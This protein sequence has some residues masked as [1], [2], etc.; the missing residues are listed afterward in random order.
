MLQSNGFSLEQVRGTVEQL[1]VQ[2]SY[3]L[4]VNHI[5]LLSAVVF[6][7][8]A[9]MIWLAPRPARIVEVGAAH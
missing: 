8:A 3:T 5:F 1:V 9:M 6:A 2:E 7:A 4:S